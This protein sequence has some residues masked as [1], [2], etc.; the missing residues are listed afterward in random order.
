MDAGKIIAVIVVII[1][2]LMTYRYIPIPALETNKTTGDAVLVFKALG[3]ACSPARNTSIKAVTDARYSQRW[4][5]RD[6]CG[7][8]GKT[9]GV[10]WRYLDLSETDKFADEALTI[11]LLECRCFTCDEGVKR[12]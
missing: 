9:S 7:T 10:K 5:C 3:P 1:V 6:F 12:T 4:E 11:P 8:L 2:V